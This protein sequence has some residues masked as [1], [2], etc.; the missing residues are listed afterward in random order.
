MSRIL[1][2]RTE[3]LLERNVI[4]Q[5]E[6]MGL[7]KKLLGKIFLTCVMQEIRLDDHSGSF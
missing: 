1:Q 6:V 5:I 4:V 3:C 7:I 2:I